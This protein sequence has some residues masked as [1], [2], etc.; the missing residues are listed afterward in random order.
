M[1]ITINLKSVRY[2]LTGTA[3]CTE[4]RI[5]LTL[6]WE[7]SWGEL[8]VIVVHEVAHMACHDEEWHGPAWRQMFLDLLREGCGLDVGWPTKDGKE[9]PYNVAHASFVQMIDEGLGWAPPAAT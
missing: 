9:V 3:Y 7:C 4:S 5:A 8:T 6:P 1:F 2:S